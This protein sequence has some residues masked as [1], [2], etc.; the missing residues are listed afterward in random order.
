MVLLIQCVILCIIFTLL[1][2]PPLFKNPL[3]QIL[4][5][6]P[7]IRKRVE[8]LPQYKNILPQTKKKNLLRKII[9]T[10]IGVILLAVV[11]LF[12]GK[13]TFV[14]AFVHV[15]ILFFAVNIY[16]LIVLD[17]IIFT[18]NKKLRIP[19]TEDMVAVYKN[20]VFHIQ[21]ALK[22][23]FIGTFAAGIAASMVALM[24]F[25]VY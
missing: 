23:L 16:D 2:L 17:V 8:S 25:I 5:Y 7:A 24:R 13:T 15:F 4:S 11:S 9:G 1:I 14:A 19:G 20:P 18:R 6:P 12:S 10:L 22:G 3:S 21:G